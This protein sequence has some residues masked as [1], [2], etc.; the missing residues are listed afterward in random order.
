MTDFSGLNT[1]G[2]HQNTKQQNIQQRSFKEVLMFRIIPLK[3]SS[4]CEWRLLSAASCRTNKKQT[5]CGCRFESCNTK[6]HYNMF[7][8]KQSKRQ[9]QN[10][11]THRPGFPA[12]AGLWH[13]GSCFFSNQLYTVMS[14][15]SLWTRST[16]QSSSQTEPARTRCLSEPGRG[17]RGGGGGAVSLWYGRRPVHVH[18]LRHKQQLTQHLLDEI[19]L[20]KASHYSETLSYSLKWL[21]GFSF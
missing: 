6:L 7:L 4:H 11:N 3:K 5:S 9:I 1:F 12:P 19:T 21:T 8:K 2:K 20:K 10:Q 14:S 18:G 13:S 17:Q 16:V 15:A